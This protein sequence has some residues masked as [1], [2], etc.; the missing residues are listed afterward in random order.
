MMRWMAQGV[1]RG[2]C[3]VALAVALLTVAM[4]APAAATTPAVPIEASAHPD[5]SPA[6]VDCTA[7]PAFPDV[8]PGQP[9]CADIAWAVRRGSLTGAVDGRFAPASSLT[10][11][12]AAAVL[13][14]VAGGPLGPAPPCPEPLPFTDLSA[15]ALCGPVAWAADAGIGLGVG[16]GRFAPAA[17]VTRAELVAMAVR[18]ARPGAT[19]P[20][21][22]VEPFPD[23]AVSHPLCPALAW[24][25]E[26]GLV[27]GGADGLL[28]PTAAVRREEVAAVVRRLDRIRA[29][30]LRPLWTSPDLRIVDDLGREVL[31]RGANVNSLGEYWQGDPAHLPTIP[32]GDADWDAM[33]RRGF[34]V[35]RLLITWS[36]VEPERGVIDHAYLDE[37]DA[38]VTAAAERGIYTVID[39][40]QD[41]YSAFIATED[42]AECPEGTRPGKGWDGAPAW[43][44][45]TD[46]LSTCITGDRNSAPA[47]VAAWNHFY[48]NTDGIRD[49]FVGAWAA[50]AARFAGRP[51]VAGYDLLNEPEVSRPSVELAP[52]YEALLADTIAA[53]RDAEAGAGD[54]HLIIVEPAI[55]AADPSF[56][57]I[58]PDPRRAGVD[59]EG[60]VAGPHNYAESIISGITIEQMNQLFV[61]LAT[62]VGV[63]V[64]TG[65][66]GFWDREPATLEKVRRF[67]A[68]EDRLVLGGAWWQWRQGCGDPHSFPW[69]GQA[70][71]PVVHLNVV[72]CP[73]DVDLGPNE[74]FLSVL[75]R[76][77]PRAAPGIVTDLASDP[78]TGAF[79]VHG[80]AADPG[81]E[82]VVWTP[83][84]V[85]THVV[86][87]TGL[88]D[89]TE[90][91][92]PG[93][94]LVRARVDVAD[95]ALTITPTGD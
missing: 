45:L 34:S 24:A 10:R 5:T 57:L 7:E 75:G 55:P 30:E 46:G 68:D 32:I 42:P 26:A 58:V 49:H 90:H 28:R 6:V 25:A 73:G 14:R 81:S 16:G 4:A 85:A 11:R 61:N 82:L 89:V 12:E 56:G 23:V 20:P 33:A 37:V 94:R 59:T 60:V 62:S 48:D 65:E 41:A 40:H 35:V 3:R 64:W 63:P 86:A 91:P 87:A 50:V 18:L 43:A 79:E 21:C 66:Y 72:G 83:T 71:G 19:S 95:Y 13:Y 88:V 29:P 39:M 51:E 67:A 15:D 22:T 92:V 74:D 38:A 84:R 8:D 2:A 69:G 36:R 1:R 76:A 70:D 54:P 52:L 53:I 47:V 17:A 77:Y 9:F 78:A 44:T 93:G 31:L 27:L 80:T